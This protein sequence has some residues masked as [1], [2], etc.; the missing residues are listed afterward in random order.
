MA[1]TISI[2]TPAKINL[3]LDIVGKR[4]DGYHTLRSV[5]QS[6]GI[7]DTLEI[8]LNDSGKITISCDTEGV[9]T[10]SSNLV[11]KACDAFFRFSGIESCGVHIDLEKKI[12]SMAGMGGGSSDCAAA[13]IGLNRLF[14]TDY[15]IDTLCDIGEKLG[16]DVPFCLTGGT[17]LCEGIGEILT[18]LPDFPECYIA[19]AKPEAAVSTPECYKKFDQLEIGEKAN[20]D[21]MIAALVVSDLSGISNNLYNSLE[22]AADLEEVSEIKEAMVSCGALGALMTGSGSAVFGIFENKRDAKD[23]VKQLSESC[24]FTAVVKPV[25]EGCIIDD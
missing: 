7:Y 9:P 21:D 22:A 20:L 17:V 18:P 14:K 3:L 5:F 6:V 12:P 24:P 19:V 23:C 8:S 16:A 2:K 15:D 4:P 25:S 10:D 13:L 1:D 11:W